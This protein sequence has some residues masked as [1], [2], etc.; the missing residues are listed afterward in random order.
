MAA[1]GCSNYR[2]EGEII[3]YTNKP[4]E[5]TVGKPNYYSST[6]NN[7]SG[8]LIK[9]REGRP[10]KVIGNPDHPI[11]KGKA[12][13]QDQAEILEL[14]NPE[15]IQQPLRK[16]SG[17]LMKSTWAH[18]DGDIINALLKNGGKEISVITKKIISPTQKKLLEEF[19]TKFSNVKVYSYELFNE[20]SRISSW[21]NSFGNQFFPTIK[22]HEAKIILS[23]EGDFLG[24]EGNIIENA[25]LFAEGRDIDNLKNFNRLY[26]VEGNLSL[27]GMN[28]DYRLRLR[29]D[30]Q[31]EFIMSIL[32]ELGSSTGNFSLSSFAKKYYLSEKTLKLLVDDLK[33]NTGSAIVYAGNILP[34]NV[35]AAVNLLNEKIGAKNLYNFNSISVL[36]TPFT[37]KGEWEELVSKMKNGQVGAVIHFDSNPIYH[38][39]NDYGYESELKNV[40][41]KISLTETE[42]ETSVKCDY[43]L[44]I[45][46]AFESWGD[47]RIRTDFFSLQQPVIAPIFNTRQKEAILLHWMG[48]KPDGFEEGIY[49]KYLM[50]NWEK[51]LY[52][53]L[54][55]KLNFKEFWYGSLHDGVVMAEGG[56]I[57]IK[58]INSSTNSSFDYKQPT[59]YVLALK[60]SYALGDGKYASNGWLQELPHPVSKITWD[61]YAAI[62]K[63]TA[64]AL[65]VNSNDLVEIT[66]GKNKLEIP[67]FVQPG[68]ADETITIELGYGRTKAGTV[69][70]D[71]GF[72]A[73]KLISKNFRS[74]HPGFIPKFL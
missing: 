29:P 67:V 20:E 8:I 16:S 70:T 54:N 56:N 38:L 13:A 47:F 44:P 15:R 65:G 55:S 37:K 59:G 61:N 69:G 62:S 18:S 1:T 21:Q 52:P 36:M 45:H 11:S 43:V 5:I 27:T 2:D 40:E 9:T 72:N 4:E 12:T 74:F 6:T 39:A 57:N 19:S 7:G 23:L 26:A 35:H 31:Y 60:E 34:E 68:A 46:H 48:G 28:A 14:Y 51:E 25:R 3:P 71:V 17:G 10:I 63:K 58:E 22:W 30:A 24:R 73:V 32:N 50:N 41:Y 42:N 53:S 49:H 33:K 66:V 64:E